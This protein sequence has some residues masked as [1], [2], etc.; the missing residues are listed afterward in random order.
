MKKVQSLW[1]LAALA[2]ALGAGTSMMAQQP[3]QPTQPPTA[4]TDQPAQTQ[5]PAQAQPPA[6]QTTPTSD[7]TAPQSG[8]QSQP[9][10]QPGQAPDTSDQ[11]N[12]SKA[13]AQDSGKTFS[14]MINKQGEQYVLQTADGTVYNIDNQ[15]AAKKYEG[16]KV[17]IHGTLDPDGKTIHV[18]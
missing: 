17:N 7:Q 15:A 14:G 13:T 11:P 6:D 12:D 5:P 4:P 10:A 2:M 1:I 18:Q 9:Q 16:K 8:Q 3:S